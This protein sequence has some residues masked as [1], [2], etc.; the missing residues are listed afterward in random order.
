MCSIHA[1]VGAGLALLLGVPA[2]GGREHQ[3]TVPVRLEDAR[4][5]ALAQVPGEVQ[6]EELEEENGRWVYEFD[7]KP[8]DPAAPVKEVVVDA[9]TG[10]VL[11]VED[12]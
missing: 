10:Q 9:H 4:R 11:V 1:I 5:T 3:P 12:D 8:A 6:E 7:I 2:C